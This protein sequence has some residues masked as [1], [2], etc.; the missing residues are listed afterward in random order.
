MDLTTIFLLAVVSVLTLMTAVLRVVPWR[1]LMRYHWAADVAFT[2]A[3]IFILSGSL[4]GMVIAIISGLIFSIVL[5]VGK[6]LTPN[7]RS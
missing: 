2:V 1:T 7:K 5:T 4:M 3:L 6:I